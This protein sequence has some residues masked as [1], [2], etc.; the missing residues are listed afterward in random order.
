M[1]LEGGTE[2]YFLLGFESQFLVLGFVDQFCGTLTLLSSF[3]KV[4]R[5]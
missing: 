1:T 4:T 3:V 2:T 5:Q